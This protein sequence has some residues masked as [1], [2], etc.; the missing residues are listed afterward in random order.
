M[1]FIAMD[2]FQ[3]VKGRKK[4]FDDVWLNRK[5]QLEDVPGFAAFNLLRGPEHED[6]TLYASHTIWADRAVFEDWTKS[7]AF[8]EAHKS[9]GSRGDMYLELPNFEGFEIMD[10]ATVTKK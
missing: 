6:H 8:R 1:T 4:D 2:R 7:E 10:A 3:V 5:S 9:A